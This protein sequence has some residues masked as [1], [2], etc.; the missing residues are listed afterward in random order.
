[1]FIYLLFLTFIFQNMEFWIE[2]FISFLLC[3]LKNNLTIYNR[4]SFERNLP[5]HLCVFWRCSFCCSYPA[6]LL[7]CISVGISYYLF[8][9]S[10]LAFWIYGWYISSLLWN[11]QLEHLQILHVFHLLSILLLELWLKIC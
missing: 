11:S 6:M 1:M 7:W 5:F 4:H 2:R 3:L 8:C 10:S 9:V